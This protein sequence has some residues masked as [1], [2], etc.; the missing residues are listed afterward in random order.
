MK[1][2]FKK[3]ALKKVY[4]SELMSLINYC[5]RPLNSVF[6]YSDS[7]QAKLIDTK[8]KVIKLYVYVHSTT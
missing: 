7:I 6:I 1:G 2:F 3:C 5:N 4:N 8:V